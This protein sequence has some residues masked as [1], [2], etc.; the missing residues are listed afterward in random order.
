M[1][2][3]Q[4]CWYLSSCTPSTYSIEAAGPL[5]WSELTLERSHA[6]VRKG[7]SSFVCPLKS[8]PPSPTKIV[9]TSPLV[10]ISILMHPSDRFL[11]SIFKVKIY[12]SPYPWFS[13]CMGPLRANK[14]GI[15]LTHKSWVSKPH[16]VLT[17][18]S[19]LF[20]PSSVYGGRFNWWISKPF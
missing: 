9:W 16:I 3:Q 1:V 13:F 8:D 6:N 2:F 12:S 5:N 18:M 11:K 19:T 15:A 7:Y 20:T 4:A 14:G 10:W 17:H